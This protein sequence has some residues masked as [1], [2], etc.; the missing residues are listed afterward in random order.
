MKATAGRRR[1]GRPGLRRRLLLL[2][3]P[4]A[5]AVVVFSAKLISVA[6]AG[7]WAVSDYSHRNAAALTHDVSILRVFN[8]VEPARA[9]YADGT[10]AVL[11]DRLPDAD[12]QFTQALARTEPDTSCPVRV[13]LELVRETLGDRA[14]AA[15]DGDAALGRY[16]AAKAVVQQAPSAC[17]AGNADR[18]LPRRRIR[19]DTL[20]RL[21]AKIEALHAAPPPVPA[22]PPP[23]PP[24]AA[25]AAGGSAPSPPTRADPPLDDPM[26]GLA[27]ILRDGAP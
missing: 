22:A 7:D 20:R 12:R 1:T 25:A 21:E 4:V 11:Q 24:P 3:T 6:L 13:N 8:I 23:P 26:A 2:T 16:T 18:D 19:A 17:F 10:R 9:Y 14:S 27:Q 5:V 15:S